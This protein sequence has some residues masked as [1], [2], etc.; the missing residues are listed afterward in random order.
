MPVPYDANNDP[1]VH[2]IAIERI[3][4]QRIHDVYFPRVESVILY[5]HGQTKTPRFYSCLFN[6]VLG[7]K[8]HGSQIMI[9]EL[10]PSAK[11]WD[12]K[13]VGEDTLNT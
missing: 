1:K 7:R 10:F 8:Q 3:A 2:Y 12:T 6:S 13:D 5:G 4:L 9:S 11:I